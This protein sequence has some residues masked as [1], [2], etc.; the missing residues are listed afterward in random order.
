MK[1][2]LTTIMILLAGLLLT[3]MGGLG[4]PPGGTVPETT[5]DVR[6]RLTDRSG[7]TTDL[8]RFSMDGEV[9]LVGR[10]GDGEASVLFRDL[11]RID[12]GQVKGQEVPGDLYLAS[13][14]SV[15][16]YIPKRLVF[17]GRT[18]FGAFRIQARDI[19]RIEFRKVES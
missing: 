15:R 11:D 16:L 6:V 12:F 7:L 5:E 8:S 4:G 14:K 19:Q 18:E 2:L 1:S 17:Y 13:G 9:Y 3:G 10:R